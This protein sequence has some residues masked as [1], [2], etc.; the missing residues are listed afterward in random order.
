MELQSQKV[1]FL[2]LH[3]STNLYISSNSHITNIRL[4]RPKAERI[5]LLHRSLGGKYT[6]DFLL[7]VPTSSFQIAI[8]TS[9]VLL[10]LFLRS[11]TCEPIRSTQCERM[12]IIPDG[13]PPSP[14]ISGCFLVDGNVVYATVPFIIVLFNDTRALSSLAI[15]L[16]SNDFPPVIM[17]YTLWIGLRNYRHSKNPLIVALYRD[18]ITYYLFL[19]SESYADILC[20]PNTSEQLYPR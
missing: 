15:Y 20:R 13:P 18:G 10:A 5:G 16:S 4:E 7:S 8:L 14:N 1:A 3:T 19:C 2:S 17:A 12:L 9:I 11:S 6:P